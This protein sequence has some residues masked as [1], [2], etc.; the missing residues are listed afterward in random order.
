MNRDELY[1]ILRAI[2]VE[3]SETDDSFKP[4]PEKP[5][6][7]ASLADLEI[8]MISAQEY[9]KLLDGR[10]PTKKFRIPPVLIEKL[11]LYKNLAELCDYLIE[12][13]FE[14]QSDNES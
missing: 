1:K 13:G 5:N 12:N 9:F 3:L 11:H 14:K 10:V 6:W 8:D 7:E 2:S 4:L